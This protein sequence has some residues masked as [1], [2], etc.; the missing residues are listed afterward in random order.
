VNPLTEAGRRVS[1]QRGVGDDHDE[2]AGAASLPTG[3]PAPAPRLRVLLAATR[4]LG[5]LWHALAGL[6]LGAAA[7]ALGTLWG[8]GLLLLAFGYLRE[9]AQH[10]WLLTPHQWLEAIAWAAGGLV[11]AF[12]WRALA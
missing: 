6:A 4:D 10:G 8:V 9:Q 1:D 2:L 12:A 7:A 11:G 5:W 3:R